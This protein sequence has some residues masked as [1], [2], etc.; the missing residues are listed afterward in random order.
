VGLI[1][2][3]ARAVHALAENATAEFEARGAPDPGARAGQL[4]ALLANPYVDMG[5]ATVGGHLGGGRT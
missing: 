2:L 4:G 1:S 5:G 3:A